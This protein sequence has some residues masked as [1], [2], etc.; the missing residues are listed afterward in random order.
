V[1]RSEEQE[2]EA[3]PAPRR[4]W[5]EADAEL[6]YLKREFSAPTE[7]PDR[8]PATTPPSSTRSVAT[9]EVAVARPA[10]RGL[11]RRP[12]AG[13]PWPEP[14]I[15]TPI[16][17]VVLACHIQPGE[18]VAPPEGGSSTVLRPVADLHR[19]RS[20]RVRRASASPS[21]PRVAIT[22]EGFRAPA[23]WARNGRGDSR[24]ASPIATSAPEDPRPADRRERPARQDR[25]DG[26]PVPLKLGQ[27]H[28]G[29]RSASPPTRAPPQLP[30]AP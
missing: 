25:P 2:T 30:P 12:C 27:A 4:S 24:P 6:A 7:G 14:R 20:G 13:R 15:T 29:S 11:H 19:S 21:G 26:G 8:K 1:F 5:A 3:P 16:D 17:G 22:A 18:S 23:S 28:R 9:H 10:R